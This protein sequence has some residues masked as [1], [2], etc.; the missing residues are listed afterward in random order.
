MGCDKE[1]VGSK[2]PG[3]NAREDHTVVV[4]FCVD[5]SGHTANVQ[6]IESS[7]DAKED[8]ILVETVKRWTYVPVDKPTEE[9]CFKQFF[10]I[11]FDENKE[12]GAP[13]AE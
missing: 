13:E 7:G 3:Q 2:P 9:N 11:A 8:E 10:D 5:R 4:G 6:I 1:G 12:P